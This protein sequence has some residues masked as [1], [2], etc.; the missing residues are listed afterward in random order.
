MNKIFLILMLVGFSVLSSVEYNEGTGKNIKPAVRDSLFYYHTNSDDQHWYG[1]S[2]WAVKFEFNEYYA[3]MDSLTFSVD[4]AYIYLP[5]TNGSDPMEIRLCQDSYNQP[6]TE[7]EDVLFSQSVAA[8]DLQ[9]QDWNFIPFSQSF[10]DTTLWLL[11]DYPTNQT[12]Q[13]IS[14]SNCGGSQSYI[15][16]DG[17]YYSMYS[18]SYNSEFLFSISG[19]FQ[20]EG[21]DLDLISVEWE[22]DISPGSSIHPKFTIK[23]NSNY[24]VS[25]SYIIIQLE[26]PTEIYDLFYSA[27]S[28]VCSRI[29][30]PTIN[31]NETKIIATSDSLVYY[32]PD[33]SA[34]FRAVAELFC[35]TD[36]LTQN[37]ICEDEFNVYNETLENVMLENAVQLD[38]QNSNNVWLA[39]DSILDTSN[40][41]VINY[42]ADFNNQPFYTEDSYLRYSFYDLM[43]F[44]TTI[45]NGDDR[46]LGYTSNYNS[47]LEE[48]YNSAFSNPNTFIQSDSLFA[49]TNEQ[50]NVSFHY[51]LNSSGTLLFEDFINELTVFV[52]IIENVIDEPGIPSGFVI[53]VFRALLG[54]NSAAQLLTGDEISDSVNFNMNDYS[55]ITQDQDN[56]EVV[57]WLQNNISKEIYYVDTLPFT[58]FQPGLVNAVETNIPTTNYKFI[59]FPNP[60][61]LSEGLN[62]QFSVNNTLQSVE[63]KI[64]NIRGQLVKTIVQEVSSKSTTFV[65]DGTDNKNKNVSSGIYLMQIKANIN[66]KKVKFYKKAL[67]V[68]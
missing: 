4:G 26:D 9:Y 25:N 50:N 40:S 2:S 55:I 13:F 68:K 36:S 48:L 8:A 57:L 30:L 12:N 52:G 3:G 34:Q 27:D 38:D 37:N 62:I 66:G 29:Y 67:M 44:P 47:E 14:A 53:P 58:L 33:R 54:D 5:G 18:M 20:T 56:C 59:S 28:T 65:W 43:G 19:S 49:Y 46:I 35:E 22:G 24:Q 6:L 1:S 51:L 11:V 16:I 60:A 17:Y 63:L 64:H 45:F 10:T 31:S 42:F 21:T 23:N 61:K 15:P 32:L 7:P 39:Q 41:I